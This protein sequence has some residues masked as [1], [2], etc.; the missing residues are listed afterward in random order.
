MKVAPFPGSASCK[1]TRPA[2]PGARDSLREP[3][4]EQPELC[5]YTAHQGTQ[6]QLRTETATERRENGAA[7]AAQRRQRESPRCPPRPPAHASAAHAGHAPAGCPKLHPQVQYLLSAHERLSCLVWYSVSSLCKDQYLFEH[8]HIQKVHA[9]L[10][11]STKKN[12]PN[13]ERQ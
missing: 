6:D 3:E 12:T 9:F 11:F 4:N 13:M 5:S 1:K 2:A 7:V 10:E 8:I